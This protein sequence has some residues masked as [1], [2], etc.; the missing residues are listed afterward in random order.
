MSKDPTPHVDEKTLG[1]HEPGK[2]HWPLDLELHPEADEEK[3]RKPK[4]KQSDKR[5]H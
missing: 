5:P 1:N 3:N 2:A 4:P